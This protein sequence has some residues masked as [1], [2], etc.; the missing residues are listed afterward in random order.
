MSKKM[1]LIKGDTNDGDYI[2]KC[3]EIEQEKL[4]IIFPLFEKIKENDGRWETH[5][6]GEDPCDMYG[7]TD[8]QNDIL[9]NLVP[10]GEYGIHSIVHIKVLEVISIERFV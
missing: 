1:I 9:G 4:D 2:E 8:E 5:D 3:S 10:Y 7:L 6:D